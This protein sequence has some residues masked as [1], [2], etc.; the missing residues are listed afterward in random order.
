MWL[1]QRAPLAAVDG[2]SDLESASS[3]TI[4]KILYDLFFGHGG[5]ALRHFPLCFLL[6]DCKPLETNA[7]T[8][9]SFSVVGKIISDV[10][11]RCRQ[12]M[13][14]LLAE[15]EAEVGAISRQ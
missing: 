15:L 9:I 6:Y 12:E 8:P 7:N 10:L 13:G 14:D 2:D 3:C 5:A 11:G 4:L 1:Y